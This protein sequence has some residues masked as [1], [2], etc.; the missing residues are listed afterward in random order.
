[1]SLAGF[2][3]FDSAEEASGDVT[4][5]LNMRCIT[6]QKAVIFRENITC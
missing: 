6:T 5:F 3:I 2:E 1:M 4:T